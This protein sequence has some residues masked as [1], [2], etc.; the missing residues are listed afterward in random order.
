M[1]IFK[2]LKKK[3]LMKLHLLF[4]DIKLFCILH[5]FL[6][7]YEINANIA[8]Q[9]PSSVVVDRSSQ[10]QLSLSLLKPQLSGQSLQFLTGPSSSGSNWVFLRQLYLGIVADIRHVPDRLT[11]GERDIAN[12]VV[13]LDPINPQHGLN[14]GPVVDDSL[15][16]CPC[17]GE[18]DADHDEDDG[19]GAAEKEPPGVG[20][21]GA[22][23]G[24][25]RGRLVRQDNREQVKNDGSG[26]GSHKHFDD[27][28][29]LVAVCVAPC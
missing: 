6:N 27:M 1:N 10:P 19:H 8:I 4:Y 20:Y 5:C 11:A 15:G 14:V 16:P 3:S 26:G 21:L 9:C 17:P 29:C 28:F 12:D 24:V 25:G 23:G 22:V 2:D 18:V 7:L 13:V